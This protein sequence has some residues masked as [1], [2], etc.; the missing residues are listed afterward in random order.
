MQSVCILR[1]RNGKEDDHHHDF[2]SLVLLIFYSDR[3]MYIYWWWVVKG[4]LVYFYTRKEK[5]FR[6][7]NH[8][9][10][11]PYHHM[12][13]IE[14]LFLLSLLLKFKWPKFTKQI[15]SW[16]I[17]YSTWATPQ[18]TFGFVKLRICNIDL[19]FVSVFFSLVN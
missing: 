13:W 14:K 16:N 5:S 17:R 10:G 11:I 1:S 12:D 7:G 2:F 15:F 19:E 8:H 9:D 18:E 3:M 4:F 6:I